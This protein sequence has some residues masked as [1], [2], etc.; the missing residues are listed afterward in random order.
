MQSGQGAACRLGPIR[1]ILKLLQT[2]LAITH[3]LTIPPV[4]KYRSTKMLTGEP[5]QN[6][7]PVSWTEFFALNTKN[8]IFAARKSMAMCYAF[9]F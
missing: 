8:Y 5:T 6:M 9:V 3:L 1:L 7:V 4:L 2:G